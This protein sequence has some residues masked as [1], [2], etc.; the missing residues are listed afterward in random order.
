MPT[1]YMLIGFPGSGKSTYAKKL[2]EKGVIVVSSDELREDKMTQ[3]N[4]K[5]VFQKM[6]NIIKENLL[7]GKDVVA[8]ATNVTASKRASFL[9][10]LYKIPC[11]K[12]AIW[13]KRDVNVCIEQNSN[14]ENKVPNVAI[15]TSAK[16]FIEPS[17]DEGFDEIMIV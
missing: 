12:I 2:A 11:K 17:L 4:D 8:D 3:I 15:Y 5:K 7:L 10:E 6:R 13:V 14:R 1:F 16:R 9:N